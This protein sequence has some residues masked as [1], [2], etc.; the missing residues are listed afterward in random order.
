MKQVFAFI[1]PHKFGPDVLGRK[2]VGIGFDSQQSHQIFFVTFAAGSSD[3]SFVYADYSSER[4]GSA[5]IILVPDNL[6]DFRHEPENEFKVIR[7][8]GTHWEPFRALVM[9]ENCKGYAVGSEVS[10]DRFYQP[11]AEAVYGFH[12]TLQTRSSEGFGRLWDAIPDGSAKLQ[13]GIHRLLEQCAT[14]SSAKRLHGLGGDIGDP[15]VKFLYGLTLADG[16]RVS[17]LVREIFIGGDS[18]QSA[19]NSLSRNLLDL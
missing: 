5:S 8:S 11:L 10:N 3:T 7:H 4:C 14:P 1:A 19:Y 13:N 18:N 6:H 16:S 15:D 9:Q 17:E 2:R 12:E